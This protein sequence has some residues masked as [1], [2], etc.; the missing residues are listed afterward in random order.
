MKKKSK[1]RLRNDLVYG[2]RNALIYALRT[3]GHT[4]KEIVSMI[5]LKLCDQPISAARCHQIFNRM[6]RETTDLPPS[7]PRTLKP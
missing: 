5:P 1:Q 4:Y 6:L 2:V 7:Q 3:Q